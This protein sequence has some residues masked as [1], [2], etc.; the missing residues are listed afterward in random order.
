[1]TALLEYGNRGEERTVEVKVGKASIKSG[2]QQ[3]RK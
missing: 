2:E 1:V 3:E